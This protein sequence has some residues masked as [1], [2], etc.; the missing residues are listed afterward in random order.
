MISGMGPTSPADEPQP[1]PTKSWRRKSFCFMSQTRIFRP[2]C[3]R[4]RVSQKLTDSRAQVKGVY[5]SKL[6]SRRSLSFVHPCG[7]AV[8]PLS[9]S[10]RLHLDCVEW[11]EGKLCKL[12]SLLFLVL[13]C[14]CCVRST[15]YFGAETGIAHPVECEKRYSHHA[16]Q[17]NS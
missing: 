5:P 12:G 15:H 1:E 4:L 11:T 8:I 2:T 9:T 13:N 16:R 10:F 7:R 17:K 14:S 3:S 6:Q